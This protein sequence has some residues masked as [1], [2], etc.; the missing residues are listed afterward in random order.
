MYDKENLFAKI[1]RKEIPC[2]KIYED[3]N[4]LFFKDIYPKAKIHILAIPKN[5][6]IDF[7][8][9]VSSC[10][11]KTVKNFFDTIYKVIKMINLDKTG[12]RLITNS[13]SDGNQEVPHF[14][15]HI[16]GGEKL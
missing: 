11:E 3:K 6:V 8:D 1:I 16:L 12:Y 7:G 10:D 2:E 13:G 5:N 4:V 9:F 14:H 15:V